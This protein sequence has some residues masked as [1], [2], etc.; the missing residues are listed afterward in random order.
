LRPLTESCFSFTAIPKV[1]WKKLVKLKTSCKISIKY[2]QK[3]WY[4][5]AIQVQVINI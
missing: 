1:F 4:L 5:I 3:E 2:Q